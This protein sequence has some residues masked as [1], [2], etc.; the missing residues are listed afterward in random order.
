M[1]RFKEFLEEKSVTDYIPTALI[2]TV[3]TAYDTLGQIE[4]YWNTMY[5]GGLPGA[6]EEVKDAFLD[7]VSVQV[8]PL[9]LNPLINWIDDLTQMYP[10]RS[11]SQPPD[12]PPPPPLVIPPFHQSV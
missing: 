1:K 12:A 4:R 2:P 3:R 6:A 7:V 5:P 9:P 11:P 8:D 10:P